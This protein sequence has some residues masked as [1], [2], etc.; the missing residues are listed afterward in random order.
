M[1]RD[2]KDIGIQTILITFKQHV[3]SAIVTG[4]IHSNQH[5][6][7]ILLQICHY[8]LTVEVWSN[9]VPIGL[10]ILICY[11]NMFKESSKDYLSAK[12]RLKS[13]T[14]NIFLEF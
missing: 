5:F 14:A 6:V 1:A 12:V 9:A 4:R 2:I 10:L 11:K 7:G 13:E 8:F 3:E